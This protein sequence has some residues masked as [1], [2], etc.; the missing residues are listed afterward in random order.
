MDRIEVCF[1]ELAYSRSRFTIRTNN[2]RVEFT[3]Y[4]KTVD[5]IQHLL[6][7]FCDGYNIDWG[8]LDF[9]AHDDVLKLI[10]QKTLS[11]EKTV[12]EMFENRNIVMT[13]YD[14]PIVVERRI[15]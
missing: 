8:L 9:K 12:F 4:E 14:C 15:V 1:S 6:L 11:G 10:K 13:K 7:N 2:V 5:D 3:V